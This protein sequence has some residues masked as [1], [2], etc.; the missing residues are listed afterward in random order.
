[1]SA[2]NFLPYAIV[3]ILT[4]IP[5]WALLKRIGLSLWWTLLSLAPLGM[6][7]ILWLI[8]FRRWPRRSTS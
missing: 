7:V 1:M 2:I 4:A 3:V 6:I 8:A 5:S